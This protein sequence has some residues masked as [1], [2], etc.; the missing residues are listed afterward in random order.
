MDILY[1]YEIIGYQLIFK[2][3]LFLSYWEVG[4]CS[5][6]LRRVLVKLV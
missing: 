4:M 1:I 3:K 2:L 6:L 5:W